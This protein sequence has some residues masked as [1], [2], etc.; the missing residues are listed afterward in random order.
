M[1][2]DTS[3]AKTK[4]VK[5]N[6]AA[7][8]LDFTNLGGSDA[9]NSTW[10][11]AAKDTYDVTGLM[12]PGH[13]TGTMTGDQ[14]YQALN[15]MAVNK[16]LDPSGT[17]SAVRKVLVK[18]VQGYNANNLKVN[19]STQD[20]K[21]VKNFIT[22]LHNNN[23]TDP[24]N[25]MSFTTAMVNLSG[26]AS[27]K[28]TGIA[29]AGL[30]TPATVPATADLTS[31]AQTAFSK[32]LGRSASPQEA[33][34]FA[35]QFQ[36]MV[37]S[38]DNSKKSAKGEASF[39]APTN[40]IQFQQNGQEAQPTGVSANGSSAQKV[41]TTTG[42]LQTPPSAD[43]AATNFAANLNPTEASAQAAAD[44][45]GQFLTMLKGS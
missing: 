32:T 13:L 8:T 9:S 20:V 35:K 16:K 37:L 15:A 19:W 10:T 43:I 30:T 25:K 42:G 41:S 29:T 12:I 45:L 4:S 26:T 21:A 5:T 23:S 27:A 24:T 40:P 34:Q 22:S 2:T 31:V 38:Y 6:T 11:A 1:S 17:W 18:S 44:G 39:A 3:T 14:L 36:D 33:A 28:G 7:D